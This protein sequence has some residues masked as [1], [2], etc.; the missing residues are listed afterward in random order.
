[1]K[2]EFFGIIISLRPFGERDAVAHIFSREYGLMTGMLR[3]AMV[4][5][6]NRPLVGQCGNASWNARLDSQLGAFH[7]ESVQNLSAA[8]MSNMKTLAF[9]NSAFGLLMALLPERVKYD[10]LFM[11]TVDMLTDLAAD[12]SDAA[13]VYL[14]WEICLLRDLGYALDLSRCSGCGKSDDLTHLSPKT[15]R[16]VCTECGAPYVGRLLPLPVDLN[17]TKFFISQ[18][19][20]EQGGVDLPLARNLV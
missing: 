11:N 13:R 9:M 19:A 18:I 6:K 15:G 1:M 12:G 4:A 5:K 20:R 7:W 17:A 2:L 16:A 3:G 8:L 10:A 14:D